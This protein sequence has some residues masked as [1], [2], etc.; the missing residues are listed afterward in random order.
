MSGPIERDLT[1]RTGS[2]L[3]AAGLDWNELSIDGRDLTVGGLA[4]SEPEQARAVDL[5]T[6][7]YGVRVVRDATALIPPQSP[8]TFTASKTGDSVELS[9]FVP[10]EPARADLLAAVQAV[11]PEAQIVDQMELGRGAPE[12]FSALLRFAIAQLAGLDDA[13]VQLSD[14]QLSASGLAMSDASYASVVAALDGDLPGGGALAMRDIRPPLAEPYFT[15]IRTDETNVTVT[16]FVPDG[17]TRAAI[18]ENISSAFPNLVLEDKTRL[19]SGAPDGLTEAIAFSTEQ[20]KGLAFGVATVDGTDLFIRGTALNSESFQQVPSAYATQ[21]PSGFNAAGVRIQPPVADPYRVTMSKSESGLELSG[22]MPTE[23]ARQGLAEAIES[24]SPQAA[25]SN[26]LRLAS[27]AP[28]GFALGADFAAQQLPLLSDGVLT[29]DGSTLSAQG[30]ASSSDAYTNILSA[31]QDDRPSAIDLGVVSIVPPLEANYGFTALSGDNRLVLSGQVPDESVRQAVLE[32]AVEGRSGVE[33]VDNLSFASGAPTGYQDQ[34]EFSLSQ[35]ALLES[36]RAGFTPDGFFL[37]GRASGLAEFDSIGAALS[38]D[39][40]GAMTLADE[41][42]S[43]P[44]VSPYEW[45]AESDG[46]TLVL[47]GLVPSNEAR[48]NLVVAAERTG[49]SVTDNMRLAA[50]AP[51]GFEAGAIFGIDQLAALESGRVTLSDS[52]YTVSGQAGDGA[53]FEAETAR[54][55]GPPVGFS[56]AEAAILPPVVADYAFDASLSGDV[57]RLS[58][59]APTVAD[60]D[61]AEAL[62]QSRFPDATIENE[63]QLAAGAPSAYQA[64]VDYAYSLMSR[65]EAG[66]AGFEGTQFSAEGTAKTVDDYEAATALSGALPAGFAAG[67]IVIDPAIVSPFTVT[68][69][70]NPQSVVLDGFAPDAAAKVAAE[71]AAASAMPGLT[72]VNQLKIASGLPDGVSYGESLIFATDQLAQFDS[73]TVSITDTS[74]SV[75][76]MASSEAAYDTVINALAASLPSGLELA[77]ESISLPVAS[78]YVWSARRDGD[79]VQISGN[80][81]STD[82]GQTISD[83]AEARFSGLDVTSDL[84]RAGGEPVNFEGAVSV[85]LTTLSRMRTGSVSLEGTKMTAEGETFTP[86]LRDELTSAI[87]NG[88]PAGYTGTANLTAPDL[89]P[90]EAQRCDELVAERMQEATIGFET[91]KAVIRQESFGLL[92]ELSGIVSRCPGTRIEVDGHTDSDGSESYNQRLSEARAN[93]VRSYMIS[94]G[95]EALRIRARGLGES[96]PIADN[97]SEEGKAL[98]RRIEFQIVN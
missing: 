56:T 21:V 25:V 26:T 70:R 9:G 72:V 94:A 59:F 44:F 87:T 24:G 78:P 18:A 57:I 62:A 8:Y 36:G 47:E 88:L 67:D 32:S 77:S 20:M 46:T 55:S 31:L 61:E 29:L 45:S 11:L 10:S 66:R 97:D 95:V 3:E 79:A 54:A 14:T 81:P 34:V 73:G 90:V 37:E 27:G 76:G 40:P 65:F 74:Y 39:L 17:E 93:A 58:G 5:A 12:G 42:V 35:L 51:E 63:L 49:A 15:T 53:A 85:A 38:G 43:P 30:T 98:N 89:E 48:S 64:G 2:T 4:F 52:N 6:A 96:Q 83:M 68:A 91:A 80:V 41:R 60:R 23:Q 19:A 86:S 50:G 84:Q 92:D 16:G 22:V 33:I 1:A 75:S 7:E 71:D 69:V 28:A 13:E 82:V